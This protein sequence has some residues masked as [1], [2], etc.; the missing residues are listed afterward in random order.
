[1]TDILISATGNPFLDI[2]FTGLPHAPAPGEEV[3]AENLSFLAG[4][5]L[6]AGIVLTRLGYQVIYET[7]L[8]R[9]LA[10]RMLLEIMEAEGLS[11]EAVTID[12]DLRACVTVAYNHAGD[13]SFLSFA[14]LTPPPNPDLVERYH[15]RAVLADGLRLDE[16]IITTLRRARACGA[17]RLAD[18]QDLAPTLA[19]EG[20]PEL[21]SQF[22]V[23]TLNE[24]EAL[25]LTGL[26]DLEAALSLLH[27]LVPLVVLK[28]GERGARA[29]WQAESVELPALP[30]TVVDLTGCGDN[31]FAALTAALL[32]GRPLTECL[33]W[34][35]VAGSLAAGAPGGTARHYTKETLLTLAADFYGPRLMPDALRRFSLIPNK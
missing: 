19:D 20:C 30:T 4:G 27:S 25:Q 7:H 23:I 21:L 33:A 16:T 34:S 17:L 9:D 24:R 12:P 26:Q 11:T 32:D 1:M 29:I 35:N 31:F 18:V 2:V 22:D 15:P 14:P 28:M 3:E 5:S 10:S 6:T 8:G 13:R